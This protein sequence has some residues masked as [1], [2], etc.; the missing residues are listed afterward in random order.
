MFDGFSFDLFALFDDGFN[1]DKVAISGLYVALS[2]VVMLVV[3]AF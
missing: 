3:I 2:F 1:Y